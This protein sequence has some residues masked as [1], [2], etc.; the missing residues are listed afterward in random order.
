MAWLC[1]QE[2][3]PEDTLRPVGCSACSPTTG[4]QGI[5]WKR[6]SKSSKHTLG[7]ARQPWSHR[8]EAK[9]AGRH[10]LIYLPENRLA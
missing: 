2:Q 5:T 6:L 1:L 8:G 10:G 7:T 4:S 9:R 3:A